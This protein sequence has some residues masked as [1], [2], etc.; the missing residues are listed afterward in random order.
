MTEREAEQKES[1]LIEARLSRS[2]LLSSSLGEDHGAS[3]PAIE[4]HSRLELLLDHCW[5]TRGRKQTGRSG[6]KHSMLG[7]LLKWW[8]GLLLLFAVVPRMK[9]V[10]RQTVDV[11]LE[12][13]QGPEAT[14]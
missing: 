11:P 1:D 2:Q 6:E 5:Q 7:L 3:R 12:A 14:F 9:A 8:L 10:A 13:Q 4:S